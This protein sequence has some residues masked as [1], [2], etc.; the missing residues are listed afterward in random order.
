M[1]HVASVKSF[2]S[3]TKNDGMENMD[4][5]ELESQLFL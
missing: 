3:R 5:S 1:C 2:F 4:L